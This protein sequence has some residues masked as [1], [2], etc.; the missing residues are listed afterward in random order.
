MTKLP[1]TRCRCGRCPL[2]YAYKNKVQAQ[3]HRRSIKRGHPAHRREPVNPFIDPEERMLATW[4]GPS[5]SSVSSLD[6]Y[7]MF[8]F[9][10]R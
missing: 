10:Y 2:C 6:P 9:A 1:D 5:F 4:T 3:K 8:V 7:A